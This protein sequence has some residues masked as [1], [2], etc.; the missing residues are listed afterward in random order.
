[1]NFK[2]RFGAEAARLAKSASA[3]A[4]EKLASG[5][6]AGARLLAI[7]K[8]QDDRPLSA[9]SLLELLVHAVHAD[10]P[11]T[12]SERDVKRSGKRRLRIAGMAGMAGGPIGMCI[13][14]M[15][16][17]VAI[18]CDVVDCHRL[19]LSDG[20]IA[21]HLLVLW[22]AMPDFETATAA[23]DGSGQTVMARAAARVHD[24]VVREPRA[25][26]TKKDVVLA[27]WRLRGEVKNVSLPGSGPRDVFLPGS[28]VTAVTEAA[29][30]QLGVTHKDDG[31]FRRFRQ[32]SQEPETNSR[33]GGYQ[34]LSYA[35][36]AQGNSSGR[37]AAEHDPRVTSREGPSEPPP[38]PPDG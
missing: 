27:L 7:I 2:N 25:E 9:E 23:I 12:L 32:T 11:Q 31:R 38:L 26:M 10:E 21:A 36:L 6:K 24:K 35:G 5:D 33:D 37:P 30:R 20:A 29:Q 16:C 13:A 22:N 1:M 18:V 28:R 15:Y 14:S 8:M 34:G 17:E 3:K 4:D 19:G